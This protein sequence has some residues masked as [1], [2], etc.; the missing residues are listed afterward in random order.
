V[1]RGGSDRRA[2]GAD[3]GRPLVGGPGAALVRAGEGA[4]VQGGGHAEG[5]REPL[6]SGVGLHVRVDQARQ[7]GRP[8]PVDVL[9]TGRNVIGHRSDDPAGDH[10]DLRARLFTAVEDSRSDDR[11]IGGE[12]AGRRV[13]A[14]LRLAHGGSR[15][16]RR[17]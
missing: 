3:V 9:D 8:A 12:V 11:E 1:A 6:G 16:R 2:G 15:D 13:V 4:H 10:D 7:Q 14:G 5:E 17:C